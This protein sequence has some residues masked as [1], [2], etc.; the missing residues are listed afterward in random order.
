MV[1]V[2]LLEAGAERYGQTEY[3]D[4]SAVLV[5]ARLTRVRFSQDLT[6]HSGMGNDAT[7]YR[8]SDHVEI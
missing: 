7:S 6:K 3:Q 2:L 4:I 1:E 8:I 5:A